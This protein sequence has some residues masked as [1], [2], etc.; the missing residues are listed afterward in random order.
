MKGFRGWLSKES[1]TTNPDELVG[2]NVLVKVTASGICGTDIHHIQRDVVLGHEGV[3]IV[4]DVGP[5]VKYLKKGTLVA[6]GFVTVTP[7]WSEVFLHIVPNSISD[8]DAAPLQCGGATAFTALEG[9]Q[10]TD[11]VAIMGVGGLGHLCIQFA[12]KL[13]CRVVVLSGTGSKRE[14]ALTLGAHKFISMADHKPEDF[15]DEWKIHRL[16]IATSVPPKWEILLPTLAPKVVVYALSVF[17]PIWRCLIC[18][19]FSTGFP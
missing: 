18:H 7:V 4:E 2:D 13:G 1:T 6:W 8:E 19:S 16:L 5:Q 12:N 3:G 9:V 11:T 14:E 15:D 10:P 17:P